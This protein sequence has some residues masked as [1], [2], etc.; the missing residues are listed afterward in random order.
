MREDI[1]ESSS[2][3]PRFRRHKGALGL[4]ERF[5]LICIPVN[6]VVTILDV[7]LSFGKSVW[8]EQY[9]AVFLGLVMGL[10]PLLVPATKTSPRDKLPWYDALLAVLGLVLGLYVVLFYPDI[11]TTSGLTPL[12]RTIMGAIAIL[13]ILECCRRLLGWA[14]V[15]I[16]AMFVL[17]GHFSYLLPG[18]L[19]SRG[20]P[21]IR[22]ANYLYLDPGALFGLPLRIV[23]TT[24]LAFIF[25]GRLFFSTGGGNFLS[26]AATSLM[27]RFRGGAAKAS[28]VASSA[29]GTISG[30][31][32][33]NVVTT[34]FFTIPLMKKVGYTPHFAAAVEATASTGGQIMPPVMGITAF[35][36][37]ELLNVPYAKVALAALMP[38]VIYYVGV[39][40][41]VDLEAA[42]SGL[43]GLPREAVP[44]LKKVVLEGWIFIIPLIVLTYL[45]F[46]LL[47]DPDIA[48]LYTIA[49]TCIVCMFK[50]ASR[51]DVKKLMSILEL[52]G[53][54]LLE[55]GIIV[56]A[57][58][59]ILGV[60]A[61]SGL[62]FSF[63]MALTEVAGGNFF[64][65]L[66]LAAG[67][68]IV[69]GMGMPVLAS[70]VLV[71]LL[72]APA[73]TKTGMV[74]L[75]AH[76]FVFYFA[77]LSF[78][79]PPICLAVYT[80][81]SLANSN[82]MK[83]AFQAVRLGIAAYI[84]PFIF[85]FSPAL[86]LIGSPVAAFT[87]IIFAIVGIMILSIGLEGYLLRHLHWVERIITV[88][89]GIALMSPSW[90]GRGA[91]A[92]LL[93]AVIFRHWRKG[94]LGVLKANG[95]TS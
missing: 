66:L 14:L 11:V 89:S 23:G 72:V 60:M 82:P 29:F 40:V 20:V 32:T 5:L 80:A 3:Q 48:G 42:K 35:L 45:L 18:P 76:M 78:L 44:P 81:A 57:A 46:V 25:F 43:K 83:T 37:A 56:G 52:T 75:S 41:Q 33:A 21:W 16:V 84:V 30:S 54:G 47:L 91:G 9:L 28:V 94:R 7:F 4:T 10:V 87:A 34:G 24:V 53:E 36:M 38:G 62:G 86:L 31:P 27:G 19:Y 65:L 93:V 73:L 63:S 12:D 49:A 59:L 77:V 79:T 1:E 95:G 67:G 71:V 51:I 2:P 15:V 90:R 50:K 39:F 6:G 22:L 55:I 85:A 17:Y 13:F 8:I 58:G 68:A 88:V 92:L 61:V 26:G 69:L 70:Y 64:I 74:P